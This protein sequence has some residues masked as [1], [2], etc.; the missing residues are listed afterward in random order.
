MAKALTEVSVLFDVDDAGA[1]QCALV[2][3]KV[4]DGAASRE[5]Q[6]HVD[7]PDFTKVF[8]N[9]GAVG[10]FYRDAVDEIKTKEGI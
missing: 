10:E 9:T 2:I 5:G 7:T 4:E 6:H 3:Y 8:H 1:P